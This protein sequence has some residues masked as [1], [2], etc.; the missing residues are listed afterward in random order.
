M[1]TISEK[2]ILL[3]NPWLTFELILICS[4]VALF[5]SKASKDLWK[6]WQL[7]KKEFYERISWDGD[8]SGS[9]VVKILPYNAGVQDWSL[10]Q[11]LRPHMPCDQK[12]SYKTE[13]ILY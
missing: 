1:S 7:Y 2:L 5:Y 9:P 3:S 13:A 4:F 8:F 12:A 10:V 6:V 11:E